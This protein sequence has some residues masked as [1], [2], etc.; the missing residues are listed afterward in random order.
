MK[1]MKTMNI[2]I[3]GAHI[4][5]SEFLLGGAAALFLQQGH[6]V[7]FTAMTNGEMGHHIMSKTATAAKR[8]EEALAAAAVLGV[9]YEFLGIPECEIMPT[10]EYRNRLVALMRKYDPDLVFTHPPIDYH[11]DHKYTSALVADASFMLKV[12]K[13]VPEIAATR[14]DPCFFFSVVKEQY[15]RELRPA[16]CIPIDTVFEQKFRALH[17]HE[18]QMYEW[19]PWVSG[20]TEPVPEEKDAR[21]KFLINWRAGAYRNIADKYRDMLVS[22]YGQDGKKVR[23]AEMVFYAPF[24]RQLNENELKTVFQFNLNRNN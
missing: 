6:Q 3:I 13:A 19:L 2:M 12:P 10:V 18:S 22:Q 8:H 5:D 9:K 7:V 14:K 17:C 15:M 1:T 21:L 20:M 11:P 23:Y 4:D 16:F 24:G